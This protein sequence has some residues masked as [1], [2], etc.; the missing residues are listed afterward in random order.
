LI[1]KKIISYEK[2]NSDVINIALT[3]VV[4]LLTYMYRNADVISKNSTSL[5][6]III[7]V[8]E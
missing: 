7:D 4:L 1:E 2:E 6:R 3:D 8:I 5:E